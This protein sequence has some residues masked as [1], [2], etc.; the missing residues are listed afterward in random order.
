MAPE[1]S[2]QADLVGVPLATLSLLKAVSPIL[3]ALSADGVS[4]LAV[5]Q[6]VDIGRC[7]SA[8][9]PLAMQVPDALTRSSSATL[10]RIQPLAA[11]VGWIPN[12]T[13]RLLSQ[14]AGGRASALLVLCLVEMFCR[15]ST[16]HLLFELSNRILLPKQREAS[17][18]E[19]SDLAEVVSNRLKPIAFGQHHAVQVTRIR[20]TYLNSGIDIPYS[21]SQSLLDRLSVECMVELLDAVRQATRDETVRVHIKGFQG[22]GGIVS[23]LMGLCPEDVLL[24]VEKGI[25]F[26]G[27]RSSITISVEYK[28]TLSISIERIVRESKS[29]SEIP[30]S[31]R[32]NDF[33]AHPGRLSQYDHLTM[34]TEGCL[35]EM[36]ELLLAVNSGGHNHV[37]SAFVNLI[38]AIIFSFKGLDFGSLA[39]FPRDGL[40]SLFGARACDHI[41]KKLSLL[42]CVEPDLDNIDLIENFNTFAQCIGSHLQC[43]CSRCECDQSHPLASCTSDGVPCLLRSVWGGFQTLAGLAVLLCFVDTDLQALTI[44][45]DPRAKL[46]PYLCRRL[47]HYVYLH[48]HS[49]LHVRNAPNT[50]DGYTIRDLHSDLCQFLG[51][52]PTNVG[53]GHNILGTT[54]GATS[55]LPL[56]LKISPTEDRLVC[57]ILLDGQYHDG[58]NYYKAITEKVVSQPRPLATHSI[59]QLPNAIPLSGIGAHSSL[60]L[61]LRSHHNS[62]VLRTIVEFP[63]HVLEIS[64]H[65]VNLAYMAASVTYPC[66]HHSEGVVNL[67]DSTSIIATAVDA[68]VA[69]HGRISMVLTRG[70]GDA[71]MLAGVLGVPALLQGRSCLNCMIK[72]AKENGF[73]LLIQG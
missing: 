21:I 14:T 73:R 37:I 62:L 34:K 1:V 28:E 12:D 3:R 29:S 66:A 63:A 36:A 50:S 16:G 35:A 24:L 23:L 30:V 42:F 25:V 65:D 52:K 27:L 64:F 68:P 72:D 31:F 9:G 55:I 41:R 22:L 47:L 2:L 18:G 6:L 5:H 57:Y 7:F 40:P 69:S 33:F 8:S 61:S 53:E 51:S 13:A 11:M 38:G 39:D 20:E 48:H 10:D 43:A 4:P 71:Q 45:Q 56:T 60:T 44:P 49:E 26:K 54:T 46:G 59:L 19:L 15:N 32:P 58:R 67:A 70:N 17:M